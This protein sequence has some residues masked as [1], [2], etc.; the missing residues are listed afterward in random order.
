MLKLKY[1]KGG[2][3]I[4]PPLTWSSDVA[5]LIHCGFKPKLVVLKK[6]TAVGEW[7]VLDVARERGDDT[8][9]DSYGPT[10]TVDKDLYWSG[11]YSEGGS[12]QLVDFLAN[13]FK[14]RNAHTGTNGENTNEDFIF[15]AW[16]EFPFVSSEGAPATAG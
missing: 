14:L 3:V 12:A 2:E 9:P 10:N 16:A 4:V 11:N 8:F 5:S 13:G 6:I 1:P 15:M 7:H